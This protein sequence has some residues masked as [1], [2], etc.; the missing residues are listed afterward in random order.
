MEV[1]KNLASNRF[2]QLAFCGI[3]HQSKIFFGSQAAAFR[4]KLSTSF[5]L[6]IS[7]SLFKSIFFQHVQQNHGLSR[8]NFAIW[9][10]NSV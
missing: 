9:D 4:S 5:N 2:E 7:E 3:Y 6:S 8:S 10:I 1:E